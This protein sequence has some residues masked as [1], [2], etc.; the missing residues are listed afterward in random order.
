MLAETVLVLLC[1]RIHGN[2]R[3]ATGHMVRYCGCS[4]LWDAAP[5]G[6][7]VGRRDPRRWL[8]RLGLRLLLLSLRLRGGIC[9]FAGCCFCGC[10]GCRWLRRCS[11]MSCIRLHCNGPKGRHSLPRAQIIAWHPLDIRALHFGQHAPLQ[12]LPRRLVPAA[13]AGTTWLP[14]LLPP[15]QL[16]SP[17]HELQSAA[18]A[19]S[20]YPITA[21]FYSLSV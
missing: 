18:Q 4:P 19:S 8:R 7:L 17:S 14:L 21:W 12:P 13:P 15:R 6:R 1:N 16:S 20:Y 5:G 10:C 2:A 11:L 9:W 3:V